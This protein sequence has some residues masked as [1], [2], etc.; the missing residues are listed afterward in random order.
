MKTEKISKEFIFGC[1]LTILLSVAGGWSAS[2]QQQNENTKDIR[3]LQE[4][5]L[6]QDDKY[7]KIIQKLD[8]LQTDVNTV[9][10]DVKL[11]GATKADRKFKD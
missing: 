11:L 7:N 2:T 10:S 6:Y 9:K 3:V 5:F 8:G 4:Q 1:I